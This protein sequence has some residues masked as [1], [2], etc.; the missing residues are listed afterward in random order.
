M[1]DSNDFVNLIR[2]VSL[3]AM[4]NTK[5]TSVVF[6]TV[7]GVSPLVINVEQK[8]S[9]SE[10]QLVLSRNV[11]DYDTSMT[12]DNGAAK[13]YRVHN[14]LKIGEAVILVRMQG[15]QKYVV[16]DRVVKV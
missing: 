12:I 4:E 9:L 15:G 16:L 1:N 11:T 10:S 14:R 5:P 8:L 13:N 2:K 3:Q 6:G 7:I